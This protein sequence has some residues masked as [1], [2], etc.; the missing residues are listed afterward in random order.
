MTDDAKPVTDLSQLP[1]ILTAAEAAAV[2]RVAE[3]VVKNWCRAGKMPGAFK[4]G[5]LKEWR[6][7][8]DDLLAYMHSKEG[9]KK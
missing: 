8:R 7:N 4:V 9:G 2:L 3:R 1:P 6:I 5:A